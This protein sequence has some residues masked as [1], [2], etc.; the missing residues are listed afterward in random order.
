MAAA[1][2]LNDL[3]KA[4]GEINQV[5]VLDN[6]QRSAR[7]DFGLITKKAVIDFVYNDGLESPHYINTTPWKNNPDPCCL[8]L[9]DAYS[10]YSGPKQGYMAFFFNPK[11]D[12]WLIKSFKL[13]KDSAPRSNIF[14]DQLSAIKALMEKTEEK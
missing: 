9:V 10:F 13:N 2:S 3:I 11:T 4:C 5:V 8:I 7:D 1:Y 14:L 12:K 6:A